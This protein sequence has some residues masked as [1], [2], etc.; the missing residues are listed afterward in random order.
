LFA[1]LDR[2]V[3]VLD[4]EEEEEE[5]EDFDEIA[6]DFG[7]DLEEIDVDKDSIK[8]EESFDEFEATFDLARMYGAYLLQDLQSNVVSTGDTCG[9]WLANN[10]LFYTEID[11]LDLIVSSVNEHFGIDAGVQNTMIFY[12]LYVIVISAAVLLCLFLAFVVVVV[13]VV[14]IVVVAVLGWLVCCG[15][16]NA[17]VG[18]L[19][20]RKIL[21]GPGTN[22]MYNKMSFWMAGLAF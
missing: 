10:Q 11:S 4:E 15:S 5:D 2:C 3:E 12:S 17:V 1:L 20:A 8:S 7:E 6:V 14:V 21:R 22:L 16:S 18:L 9:C 13:V 19:I